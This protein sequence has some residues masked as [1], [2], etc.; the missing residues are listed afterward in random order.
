MSPARTVGYAA[1]SSPAK[2]GLTRIRPVV[3]AQDLDQAA[4]ELGDA[5]RVVGDNATTEQGIWEGEAGCRCARTS[6]AVAC[7]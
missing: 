1:F 3:C 7:R 2:A 5:P 6:S 4:E